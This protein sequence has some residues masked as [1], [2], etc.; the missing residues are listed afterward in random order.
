MF[1]TVCN[2]CRDTSLQLSI[3]DVHPD[4]LMEVA[5]RG[6]W[7]SHQTHMARSHHA[8]GLAGGALKLHS[9]RGKCIFVIQ[10]LREETDINFLNR[11]KLIP[12][13]E[14]PGQT[15]GSVPAPCFADSTIKW[16]HHGS[17]I[18]LTTFTTCPYSCPTIEF[19]PT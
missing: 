8:W 18:F 4:E 11:C 1:D 15:A 9:D 5:T 6:A 2:P 13:G 17:F 16:E 12:F 10:K 19:Y 7:H 14:R 3:T